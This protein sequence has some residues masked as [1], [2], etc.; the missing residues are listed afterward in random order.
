M[1]LDTLKVAS[2]RFGKAKTTLMR[3]ELGCV[4]SYLVG[5]CEFLFV[6]FKFF[7][8]FLQI[9]CCKQEVTVMPLIGNRWSQDR[10]DLVKLNKMQGSFKTLELTQWMSFTSHKQ[11][12]SFPCKPLSWCFR[13][14]GSNFHSSFTQP[15]KCEIGS[16]VRWQSWMFPLSLGKAILF[17]GH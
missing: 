5:F 1:F 17:P 3:K 16:M 8:I 14:T 11:K 2:S 6:C 9:A 4:F 15:M 10:I 7:F 13:E 12:K